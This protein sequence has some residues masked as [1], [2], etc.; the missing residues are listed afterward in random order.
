VRCVQRAAL[1]E[2]LGLS[3]VNIIMICWIM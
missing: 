1:T 2:F 3:C